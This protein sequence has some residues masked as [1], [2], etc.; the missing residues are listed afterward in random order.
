MHLR[1]ILLCLLLSCF[2]GR[3]VAQKNSDLTRAGQQ[4]VT[5]PLS[6]AD[7]AKIESLEK[8]LEQ[9][10]TYEF[11][12]HNELRHLYRHADPRKSLEH[13]DIIYR[14]DP[15]NEYM[16]LCLTRA[17]DPDHLKARALVDVAAENDDLA[18]LATSCLFEAARLSTSSRTQ[19]GWLRLVGMQHSNLKKYQGRVLQR[20]KNEVREKASAK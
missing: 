13:C 18:A 4:K 7:Q 2:G 12:I 14:N 15:K 9:Q 8:Q 6:D 5:S 1:L 17:E 11:A 19:E 10:T 3:V 20:L 16:F